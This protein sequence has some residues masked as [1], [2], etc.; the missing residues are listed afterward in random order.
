MFVIREA[1]NKLFDLQRTFLTEFP[2][3]EEKSYIPVM[4]FPWASYTVLEFYYAKVVLSKWDLLDAVYN[5]F[6]HKYQFDRYL[7]DA[8]VVCN[9]LRALLIHNSNFAY[10]PVFVIHITYLTG[11]MLCA[12]SLRFPEALSS[13]D[14]IL[15]ALEYMEGHFSV[16]DLSFKEQLYLTCQNPNLAQDYLLEYF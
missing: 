5:H 12:L 7:G 10:V 6:D 2:V 11:M 8:S 13:I 4:G 1:L 16:K 9:L 3:L 15:H 14:D